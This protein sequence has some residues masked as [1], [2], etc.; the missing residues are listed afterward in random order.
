MQAV[1][2]RPDIIVRAGLTVLIAGLM[3]LGLMVLNSPAVSATSLIASTNVAVDEEAEA[4]QLSTLIAQEPLLTSSRIMF[5]EENVAL[6]GYEVA[7][8]SNDHTANPD[9]DVPQLP[10]AEGPT[11]Y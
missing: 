6:P 3:L 2:T 9:D 10:W 7:P 4:D 1:V 8:A 11:A 5:L